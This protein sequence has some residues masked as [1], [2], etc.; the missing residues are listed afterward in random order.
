MIG[1]TVRRVG[2]W[3]ATASGWRVFVPAVLVNAAVQAA[4]VASD[5]VPG[6]SWTFAL[7][8]AASA[9]AVLVTVAL[10]TS[11]ALAA[12]DGRP[13]TAVASA[14]QRPGVVAWAAGIGALA[15]AGGVLAFWIAPLLLLVAVPVLPAAAAGARNPVRDGF[16]G[17][18]RHPVHYL[19]G[20]LVLLVLAVVSWVVALVL[21]LFVTGMIGAALTWVWFGVVLV[22][23]LC[24]SCSSYRRGTDPS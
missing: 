8:V 13:R 15:I 6:A 11:A 19:F 18:G 17:V 5:P 21:G 14:R 3:R 9:G 4:L 16:G 23:V 1:S 12:V 20:G 22:L 7:L 10:V 24:W 2:M